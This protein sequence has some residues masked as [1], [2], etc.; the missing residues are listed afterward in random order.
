[1]SEFLN[2]T[3]VVLVKCAEQ[4]QVKVSVRLHL[5]PRRGAES[6]ALFYG[7]LDQWMDGLA[8]GSSV[9]KSA[10]D[11]CTSTQYICIYTPDIPLIYL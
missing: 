9:G 10:Y 1:M 8:F 5:L 4:G 7:T 2:L 6:M 3:F 11:S